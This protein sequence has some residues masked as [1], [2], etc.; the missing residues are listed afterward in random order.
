[1]NKRAVLWNRL[2]LAFGV[3]CI[4]Y[5]LGMGLAV[6]FGQSLLW[7]WPAVGGLCILR[8]AVARHFWRQGRPVPVARWLLRTVRC[9]LCAGLA[10]FLFAECF[11]VSGA[12][13]RAPADLDYLVVLG[14]RVNEDGPSGALRNR[15]AA[16]AAYLRDNPDTLAVASGGQ[17]TDE[18]VSEASCIRDGLAAAGIDPARILLEDRS[19]DTVE[20]LR[21]SL[22]LIGRTGATVGVVTNDFHIYRA[23]CAARK[24][25]GCTFYG[26]PVKSSSFGFVHYAMRE[27]FAL[28]A[29]GLHGQLAFS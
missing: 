26:V 14:A 13:E 21:D 27:F 28:A 1:M 2:L 4:L 20:N 19:A 17:G 8:W 16:A 12:F 3:L 7:L 10:V 25:G 22:A 9:L 18:P 15:I 5:Y 6:R 11:V 24:L 29:D 23:L